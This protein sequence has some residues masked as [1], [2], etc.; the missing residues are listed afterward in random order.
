LK[1]CDPSE[2]P[3]P[4]HLWP[5][6]YRL[7]CLVALSSQITAADGNELQ[8]E[9][10]GEVTLENF[11]RKFKA[12]RNKAISKF[13][14]GYKPS[15]TEREVIDSIIN[16]AEKEFLVDFIERLDAAAT[17]DLKFVQQAVSVQNIMEVRTL[18]QAPSNSIHRTIQLTMKNAGRTHH[19]EIDG[20]Y[21]YD[22]NVLSA[23]QAFKRE[24]VVP[25]EEIGWQKMFA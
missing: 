7:G 3:E 8:L 24:R 25:R 20:S 18:L 16:E 13:V 5:L 1:L 14:A 21:R 9:G 12:A 23:M 6:R 10:K 19:F 4:T 17:G 15:P 22:I 2:D 11:D